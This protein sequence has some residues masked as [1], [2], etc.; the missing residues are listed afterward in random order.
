M[1]PE[2]LGISFVG[3]GGAEGYRPFVSILDELAIPWRIL[4][5][6]DR[7]G[8]DAMQSLAKLLG[9]QID[10][11]APE[12]VM[13]PGGGDIEHTLATMNALDEIESAIDGFFGID[14][15]ARYRA[16]LDGQFKKGGAKR[17]YQSTGWRERLIEDF[18]ASEKGVYGE[19]VAAALA[20]ADKVPPFVTEL[21]ARVDAI[22]AIP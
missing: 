4:S 8:I 7:A 22:L 12:V 2:A 5:D 10:A 15:L 3:V 9:R 20:G 17:D 18:L 21:L 6:G 14:S 11:N 13:L 1:S 16:A 19:P